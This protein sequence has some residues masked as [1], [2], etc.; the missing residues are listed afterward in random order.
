MCRTVP[1]GIRGRV[2]KV[3]IRLVLGVD[4]G[5]GDETLFVVVANGNKN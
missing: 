4:F 1:G 3:E 5:V 2:A